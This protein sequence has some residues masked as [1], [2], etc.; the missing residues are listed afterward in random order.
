MASIRD[1]FLR[2]AA[3]T[4]PYS[5]GTYQCAG[6]Y[7]LPKGKYAAQPEAAALSCNAP[8]RNHTKLTT[9]SQCAG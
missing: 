9:I 6:S 4:V 7:A 8:T 5:R 1:E 3:L 2:T